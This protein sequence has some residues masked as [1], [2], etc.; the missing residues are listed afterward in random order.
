MTAHPLFT[1]RQVEY[2]ENLATVSVRR[3]W[4]LRSQLEARTAIRGWVRTLRDAERVRA[5]RGR[6]LT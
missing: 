2:Y 4:A 3:L 6:T 5:Y 1:L